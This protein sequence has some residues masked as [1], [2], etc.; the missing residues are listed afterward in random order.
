MAKKPPGVW[1]ILSWLFA[2]CGIVSFAIGW[3]G[4]LSNSAVFGVNPVYY[5]FD[6][7]ASGIFALFFLIYSVQSKN[8]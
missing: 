5:F 7:I 6:A 2:A 1:R 4:V 8:K 3:Y